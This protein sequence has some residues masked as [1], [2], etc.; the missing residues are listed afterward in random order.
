MIAEPWKQ[1]RRYMGKCVSKDQHLEIREIDE[2]AYI[3]ISNE[4]E[5]YR[6]EVSIS[7]NLNSLEMVLQRWQWREGEAS[8]IDSKDENV[9]TL[10]TLHE[11]F[12]NYAS[13]GIFS[14]C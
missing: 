10:K 12:E 6:Y 1:K 8:H 11:N 14:R 5:Y 7:R 3:A 9:P 2:R 4:F 13:A